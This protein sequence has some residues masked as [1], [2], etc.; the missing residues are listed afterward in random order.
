VQT[1]T[2]GIRA[3]PTSSGAR[4]DEMRIDTSGRDR[5]ACRSACSGPGRAG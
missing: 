2:I 5:T 1:C 3:Q 4:T